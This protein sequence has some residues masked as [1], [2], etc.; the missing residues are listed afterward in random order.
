MTNQPPDDLRPEERDALRALT[1]EPVPPS[2]LEDRV[3]RS[4]GA[5]GR[6][7]PRERRWWIPTSLAAAIALFVAGVVVGRVSTL[8]PATEPSAL[9]PHFI[10]LL[11]EDATFEPL[12]GESM[13]DRVAEYGRWAE[14]L[15]ARGQLVAAEKLEETGRLVRGVGVAETVRRGF[16]MAQEGH[17]TGFFLVRA[18]DYAEA[19]GLAGE[20]PHVRY[21]GSIAVRKIDPT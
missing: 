20:S 13:S 4:L 11:Y 16:P 8:S 15:R 7:S 17:V 21:G 3:V 6:M 9:Q 10:L 19:L 5:R 1:R 14:Q 12:A 2:E 18:G